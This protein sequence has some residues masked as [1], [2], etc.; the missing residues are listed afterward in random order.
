MKVLSI[1]P[2]PR[3]A[4]TR[5]WLLSASGFDV[6]TATTPEA[7][8]AVLRTHSVQCV[9]IGHNFNAN[10]IAEMEHAAARHGVPY[11]KLTV[12]AAEPVPEPNASVS[13]WDGPEALLLACRSFCGSSVSD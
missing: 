10:D 9:I 11:I 1:T 13:V 2:A 3:L 5:Y 8:E 12:S 4:G 7:A 6:L